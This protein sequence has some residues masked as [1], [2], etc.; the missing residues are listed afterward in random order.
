MKNNK[1]LL[2][3]I[4]ILLS[5]CSSTRPILY[6]NYKLRQVGDYAAE[7]DI[8]RCTQEASFRM[9]ERKGVGRSVASRINEAGGDKEMSRRMLV[10]ECLRSMNYQVIGW[11]E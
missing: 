9:Q 4:L 1:L 6:P 3:L 10:D 2:T 8:H 5:A 7:I 11:Q